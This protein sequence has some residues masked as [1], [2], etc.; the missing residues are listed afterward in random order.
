M[1]A[2]FQADWTFMQHVTIIAFEKLMLQIQYQNWAGLCCPKFAIL[3]CIEWILQWNC[4]FWPNSLSGHHQVIFAWHTQQNQFLQAG[5]AQAIFSLREFSNTECSM[6]EIPAHDSKIK[7]ENGDD[8]QGMHWNLGNV[9]GM[10]F[11]LNQSGWKAEGG[12]GRSGGPKNVV[13][14]GRSIRWLLWWCSS[15]RGYRFLH[16]KRMAAWYHTLNRELW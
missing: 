5:F 3:C 16:V 7:C 13:V 4:S 6:T 11:Q 10:F 12:I 1:S 14:T 8:I 2:C 9:P 15:S